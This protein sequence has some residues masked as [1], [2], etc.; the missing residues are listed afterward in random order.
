LNPFFA[1]AARQIV[2]LAERFAIP[3]LYTAR[4]YATAG[5]LVSYN[6]NVVENYRIVGDYVGRILKGTKAGDLPIQ[7][8]TKFELIINLKTAKALNLAIPNT[9]L[10]IADE[11]IE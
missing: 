11:V 5:G 10:E 1:S 8:P 7:R 4:A 9:L 6:S 3:S 2:A